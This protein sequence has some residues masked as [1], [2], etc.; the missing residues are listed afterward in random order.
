MKQPCILEIIWLTFFMKSIFWTGM[1][2]CCAPNDFLVIYFLKGNRKEVL[3]EVSFYFIF[4]FPSKIT[5]FRPPTLEGMTC[6]A[7]PKCCSKCSSLQVEQVE[8][9][10]SW[11]QKKASQLQAMLSKSWCVESSFYLRKKNMLLLFDF[12]Q[13]QEVQVRW[14][15]YILMIKNKI[16]LFLK[17]VK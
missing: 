2:L 8:A 9:R 16:K 14:H 6:G 15:H 7:W 3:E 13:K 11:G 10:I 17:Q 5:L 4:L 12:M 1:F